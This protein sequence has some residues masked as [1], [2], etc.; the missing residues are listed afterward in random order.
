MVA[1]CCFSPSR[2]A[3]ATISWETARR[4]I[5][6]KRVEVTVEGEF[7]AEGEPAR[8]VTYRATVEALA[9]DNAIRDLMQMT[10]PM[11]EI[12]PHSGPASP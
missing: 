9:G 8:N 7:G 6:V 3:T 1:N 5:E 11:A 10:D 12:Q 2:P 4:G